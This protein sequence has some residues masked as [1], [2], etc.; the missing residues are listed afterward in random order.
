MWSLP[1]TRSGWCIRPNRG[2]T[3]R[4]T[5]LWWPISSAPCPLSD[6]QASLTLWQVS[7]TPRDRIASPNAAQPRPASALSARWGDPGVLGLD[8]P[9]RWANWAQAIAPV[10]QWCYR[11]LL[12]APHRHPSLAGT[13]QRKPSS[14]EWYFV[15]SVSRMTEPPW[16]A[17]DSSVMFASLTVPATH[18]TG[19][20]PGRSRIPWLAGC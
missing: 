8:V 20:Y 1:R 6:R 9:R 5:S 15:L 14:S 4:H 3:R 19:S 16:R 7:W 12:T 2:S 13:T 18:I 11:R 10:G 17:S